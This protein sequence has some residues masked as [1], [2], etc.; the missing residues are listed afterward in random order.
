[1]TLCF[2]S[3]Q[4]NPSSKVCASLLAGAQEYWAQIQYIYRFGLWLFGCCLQG[5]PQGPARRNGQILPAALPAGASPKSSCLGKLPVGLWICLSQGCLYVL[6]QKAWEEPRPVAMVRG[7]DSPGT[8]VP[9]HC[10][11]WLLWGLPCQGKCFKKGLGEGW[12]GGNQFHAAFL[13]AN[14]D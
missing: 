7:G 1:M 8:A 2:P 12:E 5:V 10:L 3:D 13:K 14:L 4:A 9:Q 11:W 6:I